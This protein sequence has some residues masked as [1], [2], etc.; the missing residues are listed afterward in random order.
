MRKAKPLP[1][2]TLDKITA[3]IAP[4]GLVS[5][6]TWANP[7]IFSKILINP[8]EGLN[9]NSHKIEA[10]AAETPMVE[11]KAVRKNPA[12]RSRWVA[13]RARISAR[14][15]VLTLVTATK[16]KVLPKLLKNNGSEK[17]VT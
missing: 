10:A 6:L 5:T 2:Q 7:I 1:I 3:I 9:R 4:V 17:I 16:I 14:A 13:N 15:I 12:P 11:A 8:T